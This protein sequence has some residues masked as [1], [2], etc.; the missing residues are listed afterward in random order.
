MA[1]TSSQVSAEVDVPVWERRIGKSSFWLQAKA[2]E[3]SS[4]S[5]WRLGI[6][7]KPARLTRNKPPVTL[8]QFSPQKPLFT[9]E[10]DGERY[11]MMIDKF[12]S[13]RGGKIKISGY[14][15]V[16]KSR[17]SFMT[18]V[19]DITAVEENGDAAISFSG[20][21]RFPGTS[22]TTGTVTVQVPFTIYEPSFLKGPQ[23]P[24]EDIAAAAVWNDRLKVAIAIIVTSPPL[25]G[26]CFA[27]SLFS[28]DVSTPE[29]RGRVPLHLSL[30]LRLVE[31]KRDAVQLLRRRMA[32]VVGF[33]RSAA[34]ENQTFLG[35]AA[36][37]GIAALLEPHNI[38]SVGK[39]RWYI[40]T[41]V[42]GF[43]NPGFPSF[44]AETGPV[45][46]LWNRF[47][48]RE[49]ALRTAKLTST[50]VAADF[51]VMVGDVGAEGNKGA[52]WD[53]AH[54]STGIME[55]TAADGS[56][57]LGIASIA[58]IS[59]ALFQV[60]AQ[61]HDPLF[62]QAA[63][64][65]CNWLILKQNAVG[66]FNGTH[67]AA[68]TGHFSGQSGH[69]DGAIA[70]SALVAAFRSSGNEVYIRQAWKIANTIRTTLIEDDSA[71]C[72]FGLPSEPN[73][74]LALC[75]AI[76]GLLDLDAE[77]PKTELRE[78][79][80][81]LSDWL[82]VCRFDIV[83][84]PCLN[85]DSASSGI[86]E[87]A[88]TALRLFTHTNNERWYQLGHSLT[89]LVLSL[90]VSNWRFAALFVDL[91]LSTAAFLDGVTVD[92]RKLT[93]THEW[94]EYVPDSAASL[95]FEVL[96]EAGEMIDFLSLVCKETHQVVIL[97]L[98]PMT[99]TSV[100]LIKKNRT[101]NRR[102]PVMDL[103]TKTNCAERVPMHVLPCGSAK[104]AA[105]RVD[106]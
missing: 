74:P 60:Y 25:H 23:P 44:T 15:R 19:A 18:W 56:R 90:V 32:S 99:L 12:A 20:R 62:R 34:N 106:P 82:A 64:N 89:S 100:H 33:P 95:Y 8:L 21:F 79:V 66:Y 65:A 86:L 28:T 14:R 67:V 16:G 52:F 77:A 61:E 54:E 11:P 37:H 36:R 26:V 35:D 45:L 10:L 42:T 59:M 38:I 57:N 104:Y 93:V 43:Y 7:Q 83:S 63:L 78:A 68:Q 46:L 96:N 27:N 98:A 55:F 103:V 80:S 6:V 72:L 22:K 49:L 29:L 48:F 39:E 92:L 87:C 69:F 50:G 51:S 9:F 31:N 71:S 70:T 4:P 73:C 24:N 58:R 76:N 17:S 105:I 41:G 1:I 94:H 84:H 47:F 13:T 102:M 53:A 81:V 2:E 5:T 30:A 75:A 91:H 88:T 40:G 3:N 101:S 85:Y 97:V